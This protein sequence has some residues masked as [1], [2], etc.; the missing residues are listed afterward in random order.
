MDDDEAIKLEMA[1]TPHDAGCLVVHENDWEDL[2]TYCRRQKGHPGPHA[3]LAG[4]EVV[5]WPREEVPGAEP[6]A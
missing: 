1:Y 5:T 4:A 2:F 3:H 6:T